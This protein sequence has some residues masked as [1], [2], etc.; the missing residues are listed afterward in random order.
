MT[1]RTEQAWALR[2]EGYSAAQCAVKMGGT[3]A[4]IC[5]LWYRRLH[6]ELTTRAARGKARPRPPAIYVRNVSV[7]LDDEAHKRLRALS[8]ARGDSISEIIRTFIEWGFNAL[9]GE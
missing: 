2:L 1:M 6:P 3:R 7:C 4:G 9:D 8:A 5:S